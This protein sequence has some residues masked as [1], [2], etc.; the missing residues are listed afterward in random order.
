MTPNERK[1]IRL[2]ALRELVIYTC[3]HCRN[4]HTP[5]EGAGGRL[6]HRYDGVTFLCQADNIH[7]FIATRETEN[8]PPT[9]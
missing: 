9:T 7:R 1:Q 5:T 2:E 3:I 8:E 6:L 4:G